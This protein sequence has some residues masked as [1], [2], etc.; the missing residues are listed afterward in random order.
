MT[1]F[2]RAG[3]VACVIGMSPV[4]AHASVSGS[5]DLTCDLGVAKHYGDKGIQLYNQGSYRD[6]SYAFAASIAATKKCRNTPLNPV[7][8][9]WIHTMEALADLKLGDY[10]DANAVLVASSF[11]KARIPSTLTASESRSV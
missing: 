5:I 1:Q 3:L 4:L 9:Y 8:M 6:A 7:W 11:W 2:I 10:F